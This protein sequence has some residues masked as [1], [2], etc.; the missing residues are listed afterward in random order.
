MSEQLYRH[1][2]AGNVNFDYY[3]RLTELGEGPL[4][5]GTRTERDTGGR[6]V[7]FFIQVSPYWGQMY[8]GD[9]LYRRSAV[10]GT[11]DQGAGFYLKQH[12]FAPVRP[13]DLTI[14]KEFSNGEI[15]S[16]TVNGFTTLA[17]GCYTVVE[18]SVHPGLPGRTP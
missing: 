13:S 9:T 8:D 1:I 5:D 4:P 17:P 10:G 7:G 18:M 2:V 15:N 3:L 11:A 16:E 6:P 12:L 14:V